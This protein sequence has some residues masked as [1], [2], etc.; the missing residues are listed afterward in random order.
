M[1]KMQK[2]IEG[3]I[4][5]FSSV[6]QFCN[7]DLNKFI[8]LLRKGIYLYEYLKIWE[9]FDETTLPPKEVF[10]CNLN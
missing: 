6:Y 1:Q 8:L 3:L 10:Y 4:K 2:I 9:K 7:G 5:K